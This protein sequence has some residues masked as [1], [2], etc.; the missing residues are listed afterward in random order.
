MVKQKS[1]PSDQVW[2]ALA[3]VRIV[4]G[5]VFLWAFL[6]KLFG[7]G[8]ATASAKA[9]INGGSPTTGFLKGVEGPFAEFFNSLA[10][11]PFADWL[12]MAGLLG[13][14]VGLIFGIGVRISV[15]A[16][17]VML[18]MMWMAS[19]PIKTNPFVDD[20]IVY[21]LVL[22]VIG[23]GVSRQKWSLTDWWQL[24]PLVKKNRWLI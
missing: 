18:L 21:I 7:L 11:Q 24:V 19:L 22:A 6:D 1:K 13:I 17:S 20:H 5:F 23:A 12:F 10:G 14:G 8:F 4:L 9:W 3:A 2:Y 16:G 15:V